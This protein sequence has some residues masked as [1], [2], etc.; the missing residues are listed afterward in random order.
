[1]SDKKVWSLSDEILKLSGCESLK[2]ALNKLGLLRNI[3]KDFSLIESKEGWFRGGSETYIF[4]F[5]VAQENEEPLDC[6]IKACVAFSPGSSPE[7]ILESWID[8]RILLQQE[9]IR[10]PHLYAKG[11]GVLIE[12][13][14]P[15]SFKEIFLRSSSKKE[16]FIKELILMAAKIGKLGFTPIEPFS[17]LRSRGN[18]IVIVDFGQ[19]LGSPNPKRAP[20]ESLFKQLLK[21]MENW[22]QYISNEEKTIMYSMFQKELN[23]IM[24]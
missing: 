22:K 1:M 11:F 4:K 18:D 13:G 2:N 6:I 20:N 21:Q 9:G 14:I 7:K 8:R 12:E 19:D 5:S 17:G 16:L 24:H 23:I 3:N 15:F 10:T